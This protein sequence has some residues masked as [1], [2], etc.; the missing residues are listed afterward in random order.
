M[1]ILLKINAYFKYN[2]KKLLRNKDYGFRGASEASQRLK[3]ATTSVR[4]TRIP[5]FVSEANRVPEEVD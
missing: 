3:A 2:S 1:H 4:R 5:L